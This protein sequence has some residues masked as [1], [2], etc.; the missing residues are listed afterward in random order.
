MLA[1]LRAAVPAHRVDMFVHAGNSL[2]VVASVSEDMVQLRS[3]MIGATSC[4]ICFNLLQPKPLWTPVY[5]G[6]VF[7]S[8]HSY[9]IAKILREQS[10]VS[11]SEREHAIYETIFMP[12]GFS[13]RAFRRLMQTGEFVTLAPGARCATRGEAARSLHLVT[14]CSD[15]AKVVVEAPRAPPT[16]TAFDGVTL[17]RMDSVDGVLAQVESS[18]LDSGGLWV[19]DVW[20]PS[21][22][23][24]SPETMKLATFVSEH[25]T[26][27][28]AG[29]VTGRIEST[30]NTVPDAP[31]AW[32]ASVRAD[33]GTVDAVRFDYDEFHRALDELGPAAQQAAERM[34]LAALRL[35]RVRLSSWQSQLQARSR[36]Q[37]R[38]LEERHLREQTR[39]VYEKMVALAVADGYVSPEERNQ[40]GTFRAAHGIC[41]AQHQEALRAAGWEGRPF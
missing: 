18:A 33:G 38:Q 27:N 11:L 12:H 26:S 25:L 9:Q 34:Q 21:K 35:E 29:K 2:A 22:L 32:H 14:S 28:G 20:D 1:R 24:S 36:R 41:E 40:C 15:G 30:S 39:V 5:W 8:M 23:V 4:S 31:S 16:T 7:I 6:S 3:F 19:G 10:S 17:R 13:P 37:L